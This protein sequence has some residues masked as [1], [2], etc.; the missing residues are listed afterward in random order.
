MKHP[1]VK[2]KVYAGTVHSEGL[3]EGNLYGN[4]PKTEPQKEAE[5]QRRIKANKLIDRDLLYNSIRFTDSLLVKNLSQAQELSD[6][7]MS[8]IS[9]SELT[10]NLLLSYHGRLSFNK[11]LLIPGYSMKTRAKLINILIRSPIQPEISRLVYVAAEILGKEVDE[12][13]CCSCFDWFRSLY[14]V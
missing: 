14:F 12:V 7:V 6:F 1:Y 11:E 2:L 13:I 3:R 8:E 9:D 5:I 4:L 10:R